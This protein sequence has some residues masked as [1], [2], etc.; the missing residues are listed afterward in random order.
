MTRQNRGGG[1]AK[2]NVYEIIVK[3]RVFAF[4]H[5]GNTRAHAYTLQPLEKRSAPA[6]ADCV[7]SAVSSVPSCRSRKTTLFNRQYTC[8]FVFLFTSDGVT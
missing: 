3:P 2:E 8:I 5:F 6:S 7:V 4:Y 1:R